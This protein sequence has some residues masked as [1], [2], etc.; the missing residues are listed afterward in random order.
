MA[1]LTLHVEDS[2]LAELAYV[3]ELS[4]EDVAQFVQRCAVDPMV[5]V[6]LEQL[7]K[8]NLLGGPSSTNPKKPVDA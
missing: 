2:A 7:G 1:K 8:H 5:H 4:G 6:C 3:A